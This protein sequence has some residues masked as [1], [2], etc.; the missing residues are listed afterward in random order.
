MNLIKQ[1]I[2]L[3]SIV[4]L[5]GTAAAR[6]AEHPESGKNYGVDAWFIHFD[7]YWNVN[8]GGYPKRRCS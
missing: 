7:L 5:L 3:A 6:A 8:G 1:I 4:A 2:T